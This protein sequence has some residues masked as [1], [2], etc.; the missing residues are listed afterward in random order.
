MS[1]EDAKEKTK[2][3]EKTK[4]HD[5]DGEHKGKYKPQF[6]F[7]PSAEL[8]PPPKP[9]TDTYHG[10]PIPDVIIDAGLAGETS[11]TPEQLTIIRDN[12]DS[13]LA[14]AK[15]TGMPW[16]LGVALH[17][18]ET[19]LGFV[20]PANGQGLFQLYSSGAHFA[21][22]PVSK[23]NFETQLA[24]GMNFIK[25][26]G[27]ELGYTDAQM[28]LANPD[29]IKDILFSYNGRSEKYIQQARNLGFT[30]GAEGSPYVMNLADDKRNSN[31]NSGWG[32]ILT[33]NGPLGKAN[34]AP[35]A[36]ILIEGLT[37]IEQKAHDQ[38]V[39]KQQAEAQAF[40]AK[41]AADAEA[42]KNKL[43]VFDGWHNPIPGNAAVTSKFGPRGQ[44]VLH[45]GEDFGVS[46]GTPFLAAAG[47]VVKV[48]TY[49][50]SHAAFCKA[51]LE[52]VG[53][54]MAAIKDPIQKEVQVTSV[55]DG[56]T[57]V[58]VYAH[59]SKIDVKDGELVAG[60][61]KLGETG[62]SG[63]STGDH[64]HFEIRKNGT[65]PIDPETVL[66]GAIKSSSSEIKVVD[67][68]HDRADH[69]Q[70]A[71]ETVSSGVGAAEPNNNEQDL[72]VV[73][74]ILAQLNAKKAQ[75]AVEAGQKIQS[76]IQTAGK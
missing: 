63:C 1:L 73:N 18:R 3:R 59:M 76:V 37:H 57:Y 47:G 17:A 10:A 43:G 66:G 7:A 22:G 34:Q 32:Q 48:L 27:Y 51:A 20:N 74:Q 45:T 56:V 60:G 24:L 31:K 68:G 6:E 5:Q 28:T 65:T 19:S 23:E 71:V 53:S 4:D 50:V 62:G 61:Q 40:E 25:K 15:R 46:T 14:V 67:D 75:Q 70:D 16:E 33:D 12:L 52:G 8:P 39:A 64:A 35:G 72:N 41:R 13:Y 44:G 69:E 55:V 30:R 26:K 11:W 58:T 9:K 2:E 36:W 38:A 29:V 42:A 49:D 54:S 21:P